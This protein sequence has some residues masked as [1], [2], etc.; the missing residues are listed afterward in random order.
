MVE[1]REEMAYLAGIIDGEG[2]IGLHRKGL[3]S[4]GNGVRYFV[5]VGVQMT[6]ERVVL[7]FKE[8]FGGGIRYRKRSD[9]EKVS[10]EWRVS[11]QVALCFLKKIREWLILKQD[12]ADLAIWYMEN[13]NG[14]WGV[15]D[16]KREIWVK[17]R[18]LKQNPP[19]SVPEGA[20]IGGCS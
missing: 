13:L 14:V 16:K 17:M 3:H 10:V 6:D 20:Y 7:R 11:G 15:G 2:C 5:S 18:N 9:V 19:M 1:N 12:Q 4:C 8:L